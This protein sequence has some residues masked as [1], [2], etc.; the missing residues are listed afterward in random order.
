MTIRL[1]ALNGVEINER[2]RTNP[3][4][5]LIELKYELRSA[6]DALNAAPSRAR[7]ERVNDIGRMIA[8]IPARCMT[9]VAIK[10]SA[11][12]LV[13]FGPDNYFEPLDFDTAIGASRGIRRVCRA[14]TA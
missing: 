7:R 4:A 10:G 8:I 11:V 6:C 1:A 14:D 2:A 13:H 5:T 3:S 9:D 12:R